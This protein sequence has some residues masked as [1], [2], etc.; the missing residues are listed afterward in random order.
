MDTVSIVIF[1]IFRSF[2][3]NGVVDLTF[4]S[5]TRYWQTAGARATNA[6]N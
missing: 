5:L 3:K 2:H 1:G 4:V 6:R